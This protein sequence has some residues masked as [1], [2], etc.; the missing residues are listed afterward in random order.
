MYI[1]PTTYEWAKPSL[2]TS[3][4]TVQG[5]LSDRPPRPMWSARES[6]D[7]AAVVLSY[8]KQGG[9]NDHVGPLGFNHRCSAI[10]TSSDPN[11][12][13]PIGQT[14]LIRLLRHTL[15]SHFSTIKLS[16]LILSP[17]QPLRP[18]QQQFCARTRPNSFGCWIK[19]FIVN[20]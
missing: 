5:G 6:L 4:R 20:S 10:S 15:L 11:V 13:G 18:H 3:N 9:H 2:L 12:V 14:P 17:L 1:I 19:V 7:I 16:Q 8:S